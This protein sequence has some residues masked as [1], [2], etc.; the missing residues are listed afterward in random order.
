[1]VGFGELVEPEQGVGGGADAV[2]HVDDSTA[3]FV[4]VSTR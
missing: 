4:G 1:V 2:A 3:W